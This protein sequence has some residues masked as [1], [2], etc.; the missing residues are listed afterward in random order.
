M[1]FDPTRRRPRRARIARS[2][3]A[4]YD[5]RPTRRRRTPWR[6]SGRGRQRPMRD[7][8]SARRSALGWK[9]SS[10]SRSALAMMAAHAV[11]ARRPAAGAAQLVAARARRRSSSSGWAGASTWRPGARRA[12]A[13]TN[14][15]TLVVAGHDRRVA[16]LGGRHSLA[17][18]WSRAPGI[19][20]MTY[21]DSAAVDHRPRPRRAAGSRR[22][23]RSATAGAVRRLAGPAAA[24]RPGGARRP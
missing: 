3:R 11:A 13:S 7:A 1:R 12:T 5:V 24:H 18:A 20:P 23:P 17:A 14:M 15:S 4:G 9:R 21:F 22:A 19:E 2:R 10:R 16:V 6:D 8:A